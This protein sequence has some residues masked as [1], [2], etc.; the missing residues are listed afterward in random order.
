MALTKA[1]IDLMYEEVLSRHATASE[2]AQ[3]SSL[4][5]SEAT[6]QIELDIATLPEATSFVDP[7]VRLYQGAF[8]RLPDSID[9]NGNFDTGAQSGL[10]ANTNALRSG[11][12]LLGLAQAFVGSQEFLNLYGSTTVT[13][14]LITSYYE[15]ILGRDPSSAEVAGW[16]ATGQNAAQILIG[17]TQSTEFIARS[18][19]SVDAYKVALA[20][21]QHPA[22]PLPPPPATLSVDSDVTSVNEGGSV[23]FTLQS[24]NSADF[25][26]AFS[27][28]L[29]GIQA[30]DIVGGQLSGT[31]VLDSQG[32]AHV[33]VTTVA[34]K[35]TEGAEQLTIAFG[36]LVSS[37]VTINDTSVTPTT[38]TFTSTS[39]E[40]LNGSDGNDTFVGVVDHSA[41]NDTGTFQNVI[42]V[43][44]GNGGF[45]TLQLVVNQSNIDIVPNAPGVEE[46]LVT[47]LTGANYNLSKMTGISTIA[48]DG[49]TGGTMNFFNVQNIVNLDIENSDLGF[50]NF[51]VTTTVGAG[52]GAVD[53]N[54]VNSGK[55]NLNYHNSDGD[56]VVTAWTI[57]AEGANNNIDDLHGASITKSFTI[58]GGGSLRLDLDNSDTTEGVTSVNAAALQG[59][60]TLV[61]LH[62]NQ[63]D[64]EGSVGD[65][66]LSMHGVG[67]AKVVI[68]TQGGDDTVT[69][70]NLSGGT[71][72]PANN[73]QTFTI[74]TAGGDDQV[75]IDQ[76]DSDGDNANVDLGSGN[77]GAD[78]T[79]GGASTVK[80]TAADGNNSIDVETFSKDDAGLATAQNVTVTV[81]NGV[82]GITVDTTNS[83]AAFDVSSV[84]TVTA[85]N[86]GN[87]IDVTTGD[88]ANI[89]VT[90]GS[91]ADDVDVSTGNLSIVKV[92]VGAGG[93]TVDVD[94]GKSVTIS[95]TDGSDNVDVQATAATDITVNTGA[96]ADNIELNY[97]AG[98]VVKVNAGVDNDRVQID[99]A[100]AIGANVALDGGDGI[101]TLALHSSSAAQNTIAGT[102]HNF[103]ILEV[104]DVLVN[105]IN[106]HNYTGSDINHVTLDIGWLGTE[107][108]SGAH[109]GFQLDILDGNNGT[110]NVNLDNSLNDLNTAVSVK[111]SDNAG[112]GTDNFGTLRIADLEQ[113]T[114]E[115]THQ[116]TG[117]A[118]TINQVFLQEGA[119]A[120]L[121]IDSLTIVHSATG[122][123]TL[124]L[125][126][127]NGLFTVDITNVQASGFTGG[128]QIRDDHSG[129]VTINAP[130]AGDSSVYINNNASNSVT[131]GNGT[132]TVVTFGGNDTVNVGSGS[133]TIH[134][135][136]GV[137]H[138][139][140]GAHTSATQHNE[141]S[142]DNSSESPF[143]TPDV[144]TGFSAQDFINLFGANQFGNNTGIHFAQVTSDAG[145]IGQISALNTGDTQTNAVFNQA[146]GHLFIDTDSNGTLD[147]GDMEI[148]LVGVTNLTAAQFHLNNPNIV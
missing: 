111:L 23:T 29:N 35:T 129:A 41:F 110:L 90:S 132:N 60:F 145:V 55:Y 80:V 46:L 128:L 47:D 12:S 126:G 136:D 74:K 58:D 105:N 122:D 52:T 16:I 107:T 17:F 37:P 25:G 8:G 98:T 89:S 84:V 141:L 13:A 42:D 28:T 57:H 36:A 82:N 137:D 139:N 59:D 92:D 114:I 120:E 147:G 70:D 45:D 5:N 81:G 119:G 64:I 79:V 102:A 26:K 56:S 130:N 118:G 78:I 75:T 76:A 68:N 83:G 34:D 72:N 43:A 66:D 27:Y 48:S 65:N 6:S 20:D 3:F 135:G 40:V 33:V 49:S 85:G 113:L 2:Q 30:A 117:S 103:E 88:K 99:R 109:N 67:G 15:H 21:G 106:L 73:G 121:T 39:G 10:W 133:N 77:N 53:L 31:V 24:L 9:P 116:A 94:G 91:G 97:A 124:D 112:A 115:S 4:S 96:G 69:I 142:F 101:D 131:L 138:I 127:G 125:N 14:A 134:T 19:A 104:T 54:L 123:N 63:V 50:A 11:V 51:N 62:A 100:G 93:S 146:T 38:L 86:G 44:N 143:N 140:L 1:Q 61:D 95:A 18:Q 7:V 87:S 22:G 144:V 148:T 32:L 108:I 71:N